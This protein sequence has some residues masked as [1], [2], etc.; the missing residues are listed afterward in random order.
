M[1]K[2]LMIGKLAHIQYFVYPGGRAPVQV[3]R[4]CTAV[5]RRPKLGHLHERGG[6]RISVTGRLRWGRID[7]AEIKRLND[8]R[9]RF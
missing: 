1:A 7:R 2:K 5:I 9:T 4:V 3:T 8:P 6:P